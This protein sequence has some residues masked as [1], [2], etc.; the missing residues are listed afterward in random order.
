VNAKG[1]GQKA[2]RFG[3]ERDTAMTKTYAAVLLLEA[4]IVLTLWVF[5]RLFT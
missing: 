4:A 5:Q 2:E 1:G 3:A